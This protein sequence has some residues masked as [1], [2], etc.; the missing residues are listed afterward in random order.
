MAEKRVDMLEP[1]YTTR[2]GKNV[3][4]KFNNVAKLRPTL[5]GEME[6]PIRAFKEADPLMTD[7]TDNRQVERL[8]P[9]NRGSSW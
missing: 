9:C 5:T 7:D 6:E 2:T 8:Q 4:E 3:R 1:R